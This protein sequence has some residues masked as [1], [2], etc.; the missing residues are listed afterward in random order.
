[1]VIIHGNNSTVIQSDPQVG[2][3]DYFSEILVMHT[4][5]MCVV[6][7]QMSCRRIRLAATESMI[8]VTVTK[9]HQ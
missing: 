2:L 5:C 1:M 9:W 8:S 4:L 6:D 7:G 3:M